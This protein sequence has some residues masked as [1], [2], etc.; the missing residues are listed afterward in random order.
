MDTIARPNAGM[1]RR[2]SSAIASAIGPTTTCKLP[3][4]PGRTTAMAPNAFKSASEALLRST[5]SRRRRVV[6]APTVIRFAAPPRALMYA[7]ARSLSAT[8]AFSTVAASSR[9]G[10][11]RSKRRIQKSNT[12]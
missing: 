8:A 6:Q 7:P 1:A 3:P 10:V 9:P 5:M 4:L 11:F 12:R 2:I